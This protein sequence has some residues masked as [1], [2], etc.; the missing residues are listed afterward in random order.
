MLVNGRNILDANLATE[1][2]AALAE[3]GADIKTLNF[4]LQ[5]L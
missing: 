2:L 4:L 5:L 3:D 1:S